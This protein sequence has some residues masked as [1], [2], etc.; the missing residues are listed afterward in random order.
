MPFCDDAVDDE[1]VGGRV[2]HCCSS[3][4]LTG[5]Q[6]FREGIDACRCVSGSSDTDAQEVCKVGIVPLAAIDAD[7]GEP[8]YDFGGLRGNAD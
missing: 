5:I 2:G 4:G 1:A 6:G 8:G 3:G 7:G